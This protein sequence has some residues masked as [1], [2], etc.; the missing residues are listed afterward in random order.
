MEQ[1]LLKAK[2]IN[3]SRRIRGYHPYAPS[4]SA[5]RWS[6]FLNT[7]WEEH[8]DVIDLAEVLEVVPDV[9]RQKAKRFRVP[10][11]DVDGSRVGLT[12]RP[13]LVAGR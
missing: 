10:L 8:W 5:S 9:I 1:S 6:D 12:Q 11:L 7:A 3:G 4:M 2:R 13:R